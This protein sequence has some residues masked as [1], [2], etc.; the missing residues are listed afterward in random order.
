MFQYIMWMIVNQPYLVLSSATFSNEL[1]CY[2]FLVENLV[3]AV[4]VYQQQNEF[5]SSTTGMEKL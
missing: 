5:Y 4:C 3:V 2:S 1:Y